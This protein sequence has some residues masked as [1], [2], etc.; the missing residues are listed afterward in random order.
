MAKSGRRR[1]QDRAR[2]S[3]KRAESQRVRARREHEQKQRERRARLFDPATAPA[4]ITELLKMESRLRDHPDDAEAAVNQALELQRM[5]RQD[6]P[7][8]AERAVLDRFADRSVLAVIQET[9]GPFMKRSGWSKTISA[10]LPQI[11]AG[12]TADIDRMPDAEWD[13]LAGLTAEAAF[14][15]S[16]SD[17]HRGETALTE[18]AADPGVPPEIAKRVFDWSEHVHYGV[19]L[20]HLPPDPGV[21]CMDL[22]TGTRRYIEFTDDTRA[23]VPPW[24]VWLG[25]VVPVDGIWRTTGAGVRLSPDEGDAAAEFVLQELKA[26]I[27]LGSGVPVEEVPVPVSVSF[28]DIDP[29]GVRL[30]SADDQK[31]PVEKSVRAGSVAVALAIPR[32]VGEVFRHRLTSPDPTTPGDP[33]P[34]DTAATPANRIRLESL[35]RNYEYQAAMSKPTDDRAATIERLRSEL[36][37]PAH[38]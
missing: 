32:I 12:G 31:P 1:K 27:L 26:L 37:R 33:A 22:V 23:D 17:E 24:L 13:I 29:R 7:T 20:L 14:W 6:E 38:P 9:L 21:W 16:E 10:R 28:D 11:L 4:E 25:G 8:E 35:L 19:W 3:A 15:H 2:A 36:G 30:D 34:H 18:A 5:Y